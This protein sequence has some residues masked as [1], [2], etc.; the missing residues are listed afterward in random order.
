MIRIVVSSTTVRRS[1]SVL[2][3][4]PPAGRHPKSP[5]QVRAGSWG[6]LSS[7]QRSALMTDPD[8]TDPVL[9]L[10]IALERNQAEARDLRQRLLLAG[11]A[12][13]TIVGLIEPEP[14]LG[15]TAPADAWAFAVLAVGAW[16]ICQEDPAPVALIRRL[17]FERSPAAVPREAGLGPGSATELVR[18]WGAITSG[19]RGRVLHAI[20]QDLAPK[21]RIRDRTAHNDLETRDYPVDAA[22][23]P[24]LL[25]PAWSTPL[26]VGAGTNLRTIRG[27]FA[28]ALGNGPLPE[29]RSTM[30][31]T[32]DQ[33]EH[34]IR[35]LATLGRQLDRE[36][37]PINY[38]R[39][40]GLP[41]EHFLVQADWI[42]ICCSAGFEPGRS[43]RHELGRRWAYARFTGSAPVSFAS[44]S[45]R[46]VR[47]PDYSS[48]LLTITA[49]LQQAV[50]FYLENILS[51]CFAQPILEPVVWSP[52]RPQQRHP[53]AGRELHDIDLERA[54]HL[55]A[56]GN[57]IERIAQAVKRSVE[58]TSLALETWPR[59]SGQ[60]AP[61]RTVILSN[62]R[63]LMTSA[64]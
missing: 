6:S 38:G 46:P 20:D 18:R 9:E 29:I 25:W 44:A 27:V 52:S 34:I 10:H 33:R 51:M 35:T 45:R 32:A 13:D 2:S 30:L 14:H 21:W 3:A 11:V 8:L 26:H 55:A 58:H 15:S 49:E 42:A 24:E 47:T 43:R 37:P 36:A 62:A 59:S 53:A 16:R 22:R 54:Y 4:S 64:E 17:T 12:E 63:E 41:Y 50:N 28:S 5:T 48:F 40:R 7:H 60:S 61:M 39:R 31:G 23:L 57:T 1:L 19:L 56:H